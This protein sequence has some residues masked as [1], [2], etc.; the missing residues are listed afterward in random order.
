MDAAPAGP[1]ASVAGGGHLGRRR[2]DLLRLPEAA[3]AL[4]PQ[5]RALAQAVLAGLVEAHRDA[6]VEA[7]RALAARA[8][9]RL[10]RGRPDAPAL[11]AGEHGYAAVGATRPA[12]SCGTAQRAQRRREARRGS[13]RAPRSSDE[14]SEGLAGRLEELP[15]AGPTSS[16]LSAD[17]TTAGRPASCTLA[18]AD[19]A[20]FRAPPGRE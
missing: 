12:R 17:R 6:D 16:R 1:R 18:A 11:P 2:G 8:R 20:E 3:A 9:A 7:L 14:S 5:H 4:G 15:R 19:R 10:V 13:I